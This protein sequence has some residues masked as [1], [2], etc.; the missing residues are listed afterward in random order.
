MYPVLMTRGS[1][2]DVAESSFASVD[3]DCAPSVKDA[4]FGTSIATAL[5][6]PELLIDE[7]KLSHFLC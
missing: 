7:L 2:I 1:Q 3:F 4:V 6:D 5:R